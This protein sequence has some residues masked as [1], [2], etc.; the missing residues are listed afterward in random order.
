MATGQTGNRAHENFPSLIYPMREVTSDGRWCA[1]IRSGSLSTFVA[2]VRIFIE[3]S[4][5]LPVDKVKSRKTWQ[6]T[7]YFPRSTGVAYPI[8]AM[9]YFI[10]TNAILRVPFARSPPS[11]M[12]STRGGSS[13]GN[14]MTFKSNAW[15]WFFCLTAFSSCH[16]KTISCILPIIKSHRTSVI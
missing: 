15:A 2:T 14:L 16:A 11:I 5:V 8:A 7:Q 6:S 1:Y 9:V 10:S 3:H 4:D 12:T 13:S